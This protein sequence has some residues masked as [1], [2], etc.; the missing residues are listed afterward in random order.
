MLG[1]EL[2]TLGM[3]GLASTPLATSVHS[4]VTLKVCKSQTEVFCKRAF[5]NLKL[6]QFTRNHE[7]L[8]EFI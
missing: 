2:G 4:E 5:S 7:E 1:L 6:I 3:G 8:L